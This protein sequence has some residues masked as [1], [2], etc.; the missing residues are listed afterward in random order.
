MSPI[1][2][3][4]IAVEDRLKLQF[5]SIKIAWEGISFKPPANQMYFHTQFVM[6]TPDEPTIGD[7]YY[8]ER[9][10][11]QVFVCDVLNKGT[12]NALTT[13]EQIRQL[14]DKGTTM[15]QAGSSIHIVTTPRV[16]SPMVTEDRIVV[17]VIIELWTEVYKD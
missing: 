2:N 11:F 8:R 3:T 5:P 13:A 1:I 17:P 12:V 15:V 9:I 4:K 14:F 6:L 7:K 16:D 10:Q